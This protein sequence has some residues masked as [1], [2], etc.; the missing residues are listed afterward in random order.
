[1]GKKVRTK[2]KKKSKS[3]TAPVALPTIYDG[4]IFPELVA[5][6]AP[7]INT[8][9]NSVDNSVYTGSSMGEKISEVSKNPIF[10]PTQEPIVMGAIES[11]MSQISTHAEPVAF[12]SNSIYFNSD[13]STQT[14]TQPDPKYIPKGIDSRSY[15]SIYEALKR[16]RR[17]DYDNINA[18]YDNPTVKYF[19]IFFHFGDYGSYATGPSSDN[20]KAYR[21]A[22]LLA[23]TFLLE[24]AS[25]GSGKSGNYQFQQINQDV[26]TKEY[27]Y[28]MYN[29]AWAYLKNNG[30]EERAALLKYFILLLS[31]ISA[32]SPW[33]FQ[34]IEG[35]DQAIERKQFTDRNFMLEEERK[36]ITIKCLQDAV[37][38][39]IG[40]LL[41]LYRSITYSWVTKREILPSNMRKF[42][43]SIYVFEAPLGNITRRVARLADPAGYNFDNWQYDYAWYAKDPWESNI[44]T[45]GG[46]VEASAPINSDE[47]YLSYK[48]FEF[49][50]CEFD[51]N[52]AKTGLA[53]LNNVEGTVPVYDIGISFDDCFEHRFNF[54]HGGELG[55]MIILD[56][57]Q[58]L[59]TSELAFQTNENDAKRVK[60]V[61]SYNNM[62]S[63]I[64]AKNQ[65]LADWAAKG[66]NNWINNSSYKNSEELTFG[67]FKDKGISETQKK[68][69]DSASAADRDEGGVIKSNVID[70]ERYYMNTKE[71]KVL[72]DDGKETNRRT[73]SSPNDD[74]KDSYD[75][76]FKNEETNSIKNKSIGI[77]TIVNDKYTVNKNL[78]GKKRAHSSK[79]GYIEADKNTKYINTTKNYS[80]ESKFTVET[81]MDGDNWG[82]DKNHRQP[83]FK[84][85]DDDRKSISQ[86]QDNDR[87]NKSQDRKLL[88][89]DKDDMGNI[90]ERNS[91]IIQ[92]NANSLGTNFIEENTHIPQYVDYSEPRNFKDNGKNY[93]Y[94][95]NEIGQG[96]GEFLDRSTDNAPDLRQSMR[97][98]TDYS[99]AKFTNYQNL[100]NEGKN[101]MDIVDEDGIGLKNRA[102]EFLDRSTDN[103][104]DLRQSM[105]D[106]TDYYYSSIL[107]N[108]EN[109][110]DRG[111]S[112][113]DPERGIGTGE[114]A[115]LDKTAGDRYTSNIGENLH[116][117]K[118]P[119]NIYE[120]TPEEATK[121]AEELE[122]RINV[123]RKANLAADLIANI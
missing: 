54:V 61:N 64:R 9:M 70:D 115:L 69:M 110:K 112:Y 103:A 45:H 48:L 55:D 18:L 2:S 123:V 83:Y 50:N 56:Q 13:I 57:A 101:F 96:S 77:K 117:K 120:I 5:G 121:R 82:I 1:M 80:G 6:Q 20:S 31:D 12:E 71:H 104:P 44:T 66:N 52:S 65:A 116:V 46:N 17:P 40:T 36:K 32:N 85:P 29:S 118:I 63:N 87:F 81:L 10:K 78:S 88:G 105:R 108:P 73:L 24:Q 22:G 8:G 53:T 33:Y 79:R 119:K 114:G 30:E 15:A 27:Q 106:D 42:D 35:M 25:S 92:Q 122:N 60:M 4:P 26:N 89:S 47:K 91:T 14:I 75:I 62:S 23:P 100:K 113:L 7:N 38:D 102:G 19:K 90:S 109:L 84:S 41:D 3:T 74:D 99:A 39:R 107:E 49:R 93:I 95:L 111:S 34:A 68:I 11:K 76:F 59:I 28:H 51:Y 72:G 16:W 98:D 86:S 58:L 21:D 37:D 97:D 67:N 43:M 94:G